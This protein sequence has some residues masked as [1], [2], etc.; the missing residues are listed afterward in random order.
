MPWRVAFLLPVLALAGHA[1]LP[2]VPA[3]NA[4]ANKPSKPETATHHVSFSRQVVPLLE[5]YC[6][7]CHGGAKPRAKFALDRIKTDKQADTDRTTWEKVARAVRAR[8]MPPEE[9]PQPSAAERDLLLTFLDQRLAAVDCTK[10]R[11]PGRLTI[12]R[13][14]RTEYNNTVRD[15]AGINFQPADD[16]PS[17]DVG[18][19]F[20]NI[21][22]VLS[23]SPLLME[24][25]LAAA[26]RVIDQAIFTGT[27]GPVVRHYA[28]SE[29]KATIHVPVPRNDERLRYVRIL[30]PGGELYVDHRFAHDLDIVVRVRAFADKSAGQPVRVAFRV[31][32]GD[33]KT[34][35]VRAGEPM[36]G[37]PLEAK[38]H[39]K[40]G[41]HR[42]AIAH[43]DGKDAKK[44]RRLYVPFLEVELP[45][46]EA[47]PESHRRLFI[48]TPGAGRTKEEAARKIVA[49]F[50]RRAFRR[51]VLAAEVER[52]LRPFQM[53]DKQGEKFEKAVGLSLQAILVSPHFLFRIERDA[54]DAKPGTSHLVSEYE[55]ATRL[56]YFLWSTMPDEEL[57]TLAGKGELRKKLDAQVRRMLKDDRAK[58]L[59]QNFGGQWLEWRNLKTLTPDRGTF[60]G[61]DEE[62]RAAMV[63]EGE[64]F[65][66]AIVR[67][68]RSI[69]DFL[70]ADFT[71]LN[72]RLAEHYGIRGVYGPRFRR[73]P[74]DKD[75][76][77][78]GVLTMATVLTVTSNPTRT[79]PVKRGKWI[80][81]NILN[82][83]PPPPPPDAGELNEAKAVTA[84]APLR[85]RMEMHRHRA[86]CV[87]CH[88]RMDPLGFALENFD[89]IGGWRTRDSTFPVD[90]TGELPTGEKFNGPKELKKILKGRSEAFARCLAEKMLTYALGRGVEY[91]DKCAIDDIVR[92]LARDNYKFSR[93]VV[94]VVRS[95]PFQKR[96]VTGGKTKP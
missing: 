66:E 11:D 63:K 9:K 49:N 76:P 3:P 84:S 88:A 89:G 41:T 95:D 39:V 52:Y 59:V 90:A 75:S 64:L 65:V 6:T 70:D 50:A 7:K 82:A 73:V 48:A 27:P 34:F 21:G 25:Y 60:P 43:L 13:L 96:R 28:Y 19:G 83:P 91:Y 1:L 78:G 71:F 81:E 38:T 10:G 17:D 5:K 45:P 24:K 33:L 62:L 4:P 77:R 92:A 58:A 47:L 74:L 68:D 72:E 44:E 16:F 14:N 35:E 22:D 87:S 80:L 57:F 67:E 31:D 53:A 36:R 56:S 37:R 2:G 26:E 51:P 86:D 30:P 79:S 54:V 23:L 42:I 18:Y 55:L 61:F 20:D 46:S 85:K 8:E 15:L 93:L 29:L 32:G 40:T 12:R 94:E 69:L